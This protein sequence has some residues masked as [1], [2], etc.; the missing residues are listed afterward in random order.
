MQFNL[1]NH[2]SKSA[3][4]DLNTTTEGQLKNKGKAPS[5][6]Q[7]GQLDKSRAG[8]PKA[9][10]EKQ[11]DA[12]RAKKDAPSSTT[13]A[14]LGS[15]GQSSN[16]T[17]EKQLAGNHVGGSTA[18]VEKRLEK[19]R[20]AT[21]NLKTFMAKHAKKNDPS[22]QVTEG[23]L[24]DRGK[25]EPKDLT[26]A[27]LDKGRKDTK[28][29][30]TQALLEKARTGEADRLVEARLDSSDSK[31][32]KHRNSSTSAGNIP[33]LEEQ[34]IKASKTAEGEKYK[35]ASETDKDLMLPKVDG[36]DGIKTASVRYAADKTEYKG[37]TIEQSGDN[38]YVKDQA[39]HRAFA[40]V[41][42]SIETAKKWIDIHLN[43]K[44]KD[45]PKTASASFWRTKLAADSSYDTLPA[46]SSDGVPQSDINQEDSETPLVYEESTQDIDVGSTKMRQIVVRF[47]P[48]QIISEQDAM[49]AVTSL[50]VSTHPS[51]GKQSAGFNLSKSVTLMMDEGKAV[52][53]LPVEAFSATVGDPQDIVESFM[54]GAVGSSQDVAVDP[55][56]PEKAKKLDEALRARMSDQQ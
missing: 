19:V 33:K 41:P 36:K 8:E 10:A 26:D 42:C 11:L 21:F 1:K 37:Y 53:T 15:G 47:E 7:E 14:Q 3:A 27:Q 12:A 38:F 55:L 46:T 16:S 2:L 40:E 28:P 50:V 32:V 17:T 18:P 39:G 34:R 52:V 13:E 48:S 30:T 51:V 54:D 49:N 24:G 4:S 5:S 29:V 31:L 20:E 44:R 56:S 35:P 9:I 23:Q 43:E 22:N 6:L 45:E 25:S